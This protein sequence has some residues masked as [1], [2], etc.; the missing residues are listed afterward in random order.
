[1]LTP[2]QHTASM[3][4]GV[5]SAAAFVKH[6]VV[7]LFGSADEVLNANFEFAGRRFTITPVVI[8]FRC[9]MYSH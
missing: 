2:V 8:E 1:M 3:F 6:R 9:F 5:K 7:D 4:K